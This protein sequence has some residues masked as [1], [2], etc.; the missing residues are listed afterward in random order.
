MGAIWGQVKWYYVFRERRR[1]SSYVLGLGDVCVKSCVSFFPYHV[2]ALSMFHHCMFDY[3]V[4]FVGCGN[5]D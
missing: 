2:V 3:E 5:G 1:G 4:C